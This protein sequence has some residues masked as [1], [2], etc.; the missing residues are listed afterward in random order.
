MF[1]SSSF[2]NISEK[3][4]IRRFMNFSHLHKEDLHAD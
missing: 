1:E 4:D 2:L 3:V